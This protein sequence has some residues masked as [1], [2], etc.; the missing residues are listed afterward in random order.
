MY[1]NIHAHHVNR[2]MNAIRLG[3]IFEKIERPLKYKEMNSKVS[4]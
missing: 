4:S 2:T 3:V 1:V